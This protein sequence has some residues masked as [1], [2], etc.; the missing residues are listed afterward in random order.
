MQIPPQTPS[1]WNFL[2]RSFIEKKI[3]PTLPVLEY[4]VYPEKYVYVTKTERLAPGDDGVDSPERI[5]I[6]SRVFDLKLGL[7]E[8]DKHNVWYFTKICDMACIVTR[9]FAGEQVSRQDMYDV[10]SSAFVYQNVKYFYDQNGLQ[11]KPAKAISISV[12]Y[13]R[14]KEDVIIS[15]HLYCI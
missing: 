5:L 7:Q 4:M 13:D 6:E 8:C 9:F 11:E 2:L 14:A 1:E 12:D 15:M 3:P 10:W